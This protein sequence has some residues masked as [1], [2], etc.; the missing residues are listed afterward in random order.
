MGDFDEKVG[1]DVI[2]DSMG[3]TDQDLA[4]D[5]DLE[6]GFEGDD[7]GSEEGFGEGQE[8][9]GREQDTPSRSP[10]PELPSAPSRGRE[11]ASDPLR[12]PKPLAFNPNATFKQDKKGNLVDS[13]TGEL[14]ARA[15]SE[16]R[17]Y[18]RVHKQASDYI[19]S[20]VT[21]AGNQAREVKGRLDRAV[22]LGLGLDRELTDMK[23]KFGQL[24]AYQLG[25]DQLLEAAQYY[26]QAQSDPVGVLKNLLARA[27]LAG[28]DIN[29]LGV[30]EG[31][32][33]PAA[34]A[35]MIRKE[36][37]AGLEPVKQYTTDQQKAQEDRKVQSQYLQRAESEVNS[38]FTS[39]PEAVPY[40]NIFHAVLSQPQFQNMSLGAI[41]DKLQLHL[42]R[43][44]GR[45]RTG[46]NTRQN[47]RQPTQRSLP[48]GRGMAPS[49]SDR[50]RPGDAG[51]ANPSM[52]YD[53]I[54]REV[55]ANAR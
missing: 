24:N 23:A 5:T 52:S 51:P 1:M 34:I 53:A 48:N 18:Q 33:S 41:W 10:S 54:I 12:Q 36:V 55:L 20:A 11:G 3:L 29:Q 13:R 32:V 50:R 49:G 42:L 22:E 15:G 25:Q 31:V 27:A 47:G 16:A 2:K 26:K 37:N 6:T 19:R 8:A 40:L 35:E 9:R 28:V 43:T 39:T 46:N 21:H 45:Q 17:I 30:Q 14:I 4:P 38:F 44:Q 7:L